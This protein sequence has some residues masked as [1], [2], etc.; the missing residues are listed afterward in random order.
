MN[1]VT[2]Q[3][4]A[5]EL[6]R[7]RHDLAKKGFTITGQTIVNEQAFVTA[8]KTHDQRRLITNCSINI[9]LS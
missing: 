9:N 7:F 6:G 2:F 8:Q 1:P 4:T 3:T 5:K